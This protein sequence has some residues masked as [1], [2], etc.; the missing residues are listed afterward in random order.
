MANEFARALKDLNK[1]VTKANAAAGAN[2]DG[3]DLEQTIGGEIEQMAVEL[4]LPAEAGLSDTKVLTFKLEDSANGT[5]FTAV[6]PLISTTQTGAS[7]A[8][9]A[10]KTVR[11]RLPPNTRRYIRVAQTA[12]AT[13]GTLA[14]SFTVSLLF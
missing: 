14:G 2:S 6:D 8:G 9:C 13:P 3:I 5:D 10:A 1:I 4:S 11:F 12:T 7:S